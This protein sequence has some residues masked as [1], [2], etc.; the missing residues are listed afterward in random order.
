[1]TTEAVTPEAPKP[2]E[3]AAK[4]VGRGVMF[5]GFAKVYF[6]LTGTVQRLL[7]ARLISPADLGDFAVINNLLD[8]EFAEVNSSRASSRRAA[9]AVARSERVAAP[10]RA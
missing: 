2:A 5:I 10:L 3:S 1:M 6:M 4:I 8:W 9:H 7:L